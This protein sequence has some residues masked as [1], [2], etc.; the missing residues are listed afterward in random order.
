[1]ELAEKIIDL[2]GRSE[3][4]V[5]GESL[6]ARFGVSRNAVWKAINNLRDRGYMIDA[7]TNCGYTLSAENKKMCASQITKLLR[8]DCSVILYDTVDS[9]NKAAKRLAEQGVPEGTLVIAERQ[10]AG[11]GR[12]GRT[13]FSPDGGVYMSMVLRP[14]SDPQDALFITV[15]A[16]VAVAEAIEEISGREC[17]IKWVN[18]VYIEDKKVCGILTEGAFNAELCRLDYAIL[19]LGVNLTVPSGGYPQEI[20]DRADAVFGFKPVNSA[21]K[22]Q[23]AALAAD[24]FLDMYKNLADR[25][26]VDSYRR[27]SY[28]DGL[29][30]SFERD[31]KQHT[32]VVVGIDGDA[33]LIVNENGTVYTLRAGDVSVRPTQ[34]ARHE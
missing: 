14:S 11:R 25:R 28:L 22:S 6:A 9:T 23:L 30:V 20:A 2:L 18:D 3:T 15:A 8:H 33:G 12:L 21:Q 10:S 24:K 19:G 27:R 29:T 16:A 32:A 34:G 17:R 4:A 1:M 13:F 7:A 5:S 26:F 31:D